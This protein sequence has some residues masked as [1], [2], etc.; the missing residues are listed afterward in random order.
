MYRKREELDESTSR[1]NVRAQEDLCP[2]N[3]FPQEI[4]WP[5]L[6]DTH[7]DD[8]L[9]GGSFVSYIEIGLKRNLGFCRI[10]VPLMRRMLSL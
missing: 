2:V 3:L 10:V 6:G 7:L 4:F 9:V 1:G 8:L 5:V